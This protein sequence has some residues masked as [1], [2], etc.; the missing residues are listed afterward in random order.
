MK[1][2]LIIV[3]GPSGSGKSTVIGR[4][5]K[6]GAFPLR[7]SVSATTRAPRPGEVDGVDYHFWTQENFEEEVRAGAFLEWARVHGNC[8]GTLRREVEDPRKQ[9]IGV[10]LD[11]DVQGAAQIRKLY[12]DAVSVFLRTSCLETYEER[13]RKRGTEDEASLQRRLANARAELMHAGEYD[14]QVINDDLA[15]AV[16][17]LREIVRTPF[18][19]GNRAG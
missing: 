15:Q 5:L 3:S 13:L 18:E 9:G 14:Y 19:K 6:E 8:Y 11:I 16:A 12:S 2:P 1:G 10:I 4:L 7:V 17:Q